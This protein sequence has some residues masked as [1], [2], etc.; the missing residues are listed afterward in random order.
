M[1]NVERFIITEAKEFIDNIDKQSNNNIH[2]VIIVNNKNDNN[3][4]C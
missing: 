2:N 1:D 3:G 4:N